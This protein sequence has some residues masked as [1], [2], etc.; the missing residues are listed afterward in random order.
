VF[1]GSCTRL[2][3]A[4]QQPAYDIYQTSPTYNLNRVHHLLAAFQQRGYAIFHKEPNIQYSFR[5]GQS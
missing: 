3:L 2:T 5:S 4:L 1:D